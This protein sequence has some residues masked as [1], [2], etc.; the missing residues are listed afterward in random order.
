MELFVTKSFDLHVPYAA[1]V[2]AIIS[3]GYIYI[4]V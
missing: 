4:I 1:E 2:T 3:Q